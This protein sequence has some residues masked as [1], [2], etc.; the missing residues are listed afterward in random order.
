M[1]NFRCED[2]QLTNFKQPYWVSVAN[3]GTHA[4]SSLW[5]PGL[6][7]TSLSGND[8]DGAELGQSSDC[9][10]FRGQVSGSA[11]DGGLVTDIH[12]DGMNCDATYI[13]R[14][15][16]F[17]QAVANA[18]VS[19]FYMKGCGTNTSANSGGYCLLAYNVEAEDGQYDSASNIF[20]SD[21]TFDTPFSVGFYS[22]I[23]EKVFISDVYCSGQSDTANSVLPKGCVVYGRV[24]DGAISGLV[25]RDSYVCVVVAPAGTST[26]Q[27]TNVTAT[28]AVADAE[29]IK[30]NA[31]DEAKADS[32]TVISAASI[33]LT[34][35]GSIGI[36]LETKSGLPQVIGHVQLIGGRIAATSRDIYTYDATTRGGVVTQGVELNAITLAGTPNVTA[37]A[38]NETTTP[39]IVADVTVDAIAGFGRSATG[40]NFADSTDV[41]IKGL[42]LKNRPSGGVMLSLTGARGSMEGVTFENVGSSQRVNSTDFG[43]ATPTWSADQGTFIQNLNPTG[44]GPLHGYTNTSSGSGTTWTPD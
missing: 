4:I 43:V 12:V 35:S 32:R 40:L 44:S 24:K 18:H 26:N 42:V 30:V 19:H 14:C 3:S 16:D 29:G 25:C 1:S 8:I 23:S 22:A 38:F 13:K 36:D 21:G 39:L 9:L 41:D 2:C 5:F 28:G 34:G 7:C 17:W 37:F 20:V 15:V 31:S 10:S 6:K 11:G 33:N 27:V